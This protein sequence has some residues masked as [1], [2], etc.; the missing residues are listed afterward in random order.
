LYKTGIRKHR[1]ATQ[2]RRTTEFLTGREQRHKSGHIS[3]FK[4]F[5][6]FTRKQN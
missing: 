3:I 2:T 6:S 4:N 1:V 5:T